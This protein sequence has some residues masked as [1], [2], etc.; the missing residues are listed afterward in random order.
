M[1]DTGWY[2][3]FWQ[4]WRVLAGGMADSGWYGRFWLVWLILAGMADS[5][6][7]GLY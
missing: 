3:R 6:R 4:V 1:A 5:G 7:H 2:G